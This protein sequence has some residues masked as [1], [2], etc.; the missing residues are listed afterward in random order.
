[1]E[2][3]NVYGGKFCDPNERQ[4]TTLGTG[5]AANFISGGGAESAGATL[6]NKRVYFSGKAYSLDGGKL[7]SVRHQKIVNVRD[8]T[9]AG[10]ALYKPLHLLIV[11]VVTLIVGFIGLG[12]GDFLGIGNIVGTVCIIGAIGS[13]VAYF[14]KIK[15]L[16]TIEYAGGNIAFDAKLLAMNEQ[17]S[18]SSPWYNAIVDDF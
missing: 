12:I 10:Y 16:L 5:F 9:G 11:A 17:D 1:M 14:L 4:I 3:S 15:T 13:G 8:I 7:A 2:N 6:T 18:I